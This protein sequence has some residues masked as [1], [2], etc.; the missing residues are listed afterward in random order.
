VVAEARDGNEAMELSVAQQPDILVLDVNLPKL[1]GLD[2][3]RSLQNHRPP[4]QIIIVT[5][6]N[7][8]ATFNKAINYGVHGYILKEDAVAD[9]ATALQTVATG[10]YYL[11][12]SM[13]AFLLRRRERSDALLASSPGLA[14]ITTAERR[15]LKL[16]ANKKTSGEIAKELFISVRTVHAHRANIAE[17]LNLRGSHSLLQF[18]LEHW[19]EL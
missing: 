2:V 17:K 15:I 4:I 19:S 6:N 8:E 11:T 10:N 3:A 12:P 7:D 5:M 16:I 14:E 13:S 9:I 1:S 18:A